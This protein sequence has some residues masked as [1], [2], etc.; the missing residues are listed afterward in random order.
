MNEKTET[1]K[2]FESSS[3]KIILRNRMASLKLNM[4]F[5]KV[6]G[7]RLKT[8]WEGNILGFD[9]IA[10]DEFLKTRKDESTQQAIFRQFGQDGVNIVR[11]LLGMKRET[12]R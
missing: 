10:F 2:F 9:I 11:E 4:P 5:I 1:Q 6:F 12:T 7:V 3:G 8:F